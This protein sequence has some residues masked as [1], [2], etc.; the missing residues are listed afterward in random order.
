MKR[1]RYFS[2]I[3]MCIQ[4]REAL[5]RELGAEEVMEQSEEEDF[6]DEEMEYH[7]ESEE[8]IFVEDEKDDDDEEE[9][10]PLA[11]APPSPTEISTDYSII[12]EA[13]PPGT[14]LNVPADYM[15]LYLRDIISIVTIHTNAEAE[16]EDSTKGTSASCSWKPIDAEEMSAFIGLLFLGGVRHMKDDSIAMIW[17]KC[18]GNNMFRA[19]MSQNR[20]KQILRFLRFSDESS[21]DNLFVADKLDPIRE[22]W[23]VFNES[24]SRYFQPG[25]NLTV[26]KQFV[27]FKG[28]C[29]FLQNMHHK[30]GNYGMI[31]YWINDSSTGFPL[32]GFPCI[33]NVKNRATSFGHTAIVDLAGQYF[34][35][36]I[37]YDRKLS[38]PKLEQKLE[39]KG[40][41]IRTITKKREKVLPVKKQA[42]MGKKANHLTQMNNLK[43]GTQ[44]M[45]EMVNKYS[46]KRSSRKWTF[47]FFCN[48]LDVVGVAA[49]LLY[50]INNSEQSKYPLKRS[51]RSSFLLEAA[52]G[53]ISPAIMKYKPSFNI[54]VLQSTNIDEIKQE[55]IDSN[56][57]QPQ[58]CLQ[59]ISIA[60]DSSESKPQDLLQRIY[61][62]EG[63]SKEESKRGK[64]CVCQFR[65]RKY[66]KICGNH[67]CPKHLI[68]SCSLCAK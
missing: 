18:H 53:L 22:V 52:E 4:A 10:D 60:D 21:D 50:R 11:E 28:K 66:C 27:N 51:Q 20:F 1:S 23:E 47:R 35:R 43:T 59:R 32:K 2:D 14:I 49:F 29:S 19:A 58:D 57:S 8:S 30:S 67:V 45:N 36:N 13:I 65:T 62:T 37:T 64:C 6:S 9:T 40:L 56:Q 46:C 5:D 41:T 34:N 12:A 48:I 15:N 63:D 33:E 7:G 24:L 42:K 26:D 3:E 61:S 68:E 39:K 38:S 55:P 44:L 31:I 54:S 17:D 25:L 16:R